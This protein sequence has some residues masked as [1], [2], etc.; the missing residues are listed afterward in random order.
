MRLVASLIG[1]LSLFGCATG[2]QD[3]PLDRPHA[4]LRVM[5]TAA[6]PT[7]AEIIECANSGKSSELGHFDPISALRAGKAHPTKIIDMPDSKYSGIGVFEHSIPVGKPVGVRF[8][9]ARRFAGFSMQ[10]N[11]T[12]YFVPE[13]GQDYQARYGSTNV[14]REFAKVCEVVLERLVPTGQRFA[15]TIP[16]PTTNECSAK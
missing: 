6:E 8:T 13:P 5:S 16:V 11:L 12:A 14:G 7:T 3:A 9:G 1:L 10:C 2:F 4:R 15:E